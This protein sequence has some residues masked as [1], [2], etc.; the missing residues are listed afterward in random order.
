MEVNRA[1]AEPAFVQPLEVQPDIVAGQGALA[2]SH[3]DRHEE[4][5]VVVDEPSL[6][7]LGRELRTA[8]AEISAGFRLQLPD[9]VRV[10]S[11]SIR[12]LALVTV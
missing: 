7:R 2:A 3:R 6:D 11:R 8:D 12:V 9:R 10:N 4:E 5:L 1:I